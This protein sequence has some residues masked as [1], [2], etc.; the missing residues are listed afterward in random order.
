M[1]TYKLS[2]EA[3][4]DLREIYKYGFFEHGEK[5][6]DKYY[7]DLLERFQQIATRPNLYQAVD[8]IRENYRRSV[9]GKHSIYYRV[10]GENIEIIRILGQQ[11]LSKNLS[12]SS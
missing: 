12:K 5:Q 11:D 3:K 10:V 6:A 4:A 9:F 8:Y 7:L 1:G 2:Q